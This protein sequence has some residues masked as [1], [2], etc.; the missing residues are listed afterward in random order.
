[1]D[2]LVELRDRFGLDLH[3]EVERAALAAYL[4]FKQE[5]YDVRAANAGQESE[6]ED[7]ILDAMDSLWWKLSAE[8]RERV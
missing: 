7:E 1:M 2:A 8:D 4:S 5:L 3:Q 6:R